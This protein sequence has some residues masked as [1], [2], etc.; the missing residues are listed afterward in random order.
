MDKRGQ[1]EKPRVVVDASVV[2]KWVFPGEPWESEARV[3]QEKIAFREVEAY[4]PPLLLYEVASVI[5]KSIFRGVLKIDD[6]IQALEALKNLG[7]NIQAV[8]WNGLAEILRIAIASKLTV[9]DSIYLQLSKKINAPLI[10][11]DIQLKQRGRNV[12]EIILLEDLN[13]V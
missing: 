12:T 4:A 9:Y 7:L 11:A 3:L 5:L 13:N 2:A 8:D 1:R 6:G 10:T